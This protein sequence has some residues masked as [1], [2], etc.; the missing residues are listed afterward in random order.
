MTTGYLHS[1]YAES[2]AKFGIP[3]ELSRSGGWIVQRRIPGSSYDDAMGCY[4]LFTCH[5]WSQLGA[6]LELLEND[7][8][9]LALVTDPFGRYSPADLNACF[10][11]V[12]PFKEHF[13]VDLHHSLDFIMDRRLRKQVRRARRD[14]EVERCMDPIAFLDEWLALYAV[15]VERHR[16]TGIKAF[17]R[18]AF[19]KQ[20][21]TPGTVLFQ[22]VANG[23]TIGADWYYVQGDVAYGHL[24]A[25]NSV[26]YQVGA[27]AVLQ[28]YAIEY[29]TNQLRWI[30]LGA[31]SG[32]AAKDDGLSFF[33]RRWSTG[34]RT[35]YFCGR[36]LNQKRYAEVTLIKGS[37]MT[38]YFPAY[39]H[40]ELG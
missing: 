23:V 40:G 20:L 39:R 26:G 3:R 16:L 12:T 29:F 8:V 18:E 10:D 7:L 33:K 21:S 6:D 28:A 27:A 11:V 30:D 15:L 4:P 37:P 35:A 2:F 36:I 32:S 22:A 24:A 25:F 9:S 17:S 19:A 14:V 1:S 34:T 38:V 31:G 13:V 5:D